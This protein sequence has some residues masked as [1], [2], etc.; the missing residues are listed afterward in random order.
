[1]EKGAVR[2]FDG[3]ETLWFKATQAQFG[4]SKRFRPGCGMCWENP[5]EAWDPARS[6]KFGKA[7]PQ[8]LLQFL[9]FLRVMFSSSTAR[10]E[11]QSKVESTKDWSRS[12]AQLEPMR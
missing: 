11:S 1:M 7:Y 12:R 2:F 8:G 5:W 10:S 9:S 4:K 3:D 6:I